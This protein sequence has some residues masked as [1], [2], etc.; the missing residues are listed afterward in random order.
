MNPLIKQAHTSYLG[1]KGAG[2]GLM[3]ADLHVHTNFSPDGLSSPKEIVKAAIEKNIDC[4]CI[5]DHHEIKGAIEAMKF[6]FDKNILIIS[7]IE[8]L[9]TSG[10]VLGINVKKI[11][12][13]GLSVEKTIEEIRKQGGMAVIPHPFD[14]PVVNFRGGEKKLC[15]IDFD[16]IEAFNSSVIFKS[17]NQK[18]FN[19]SQKNNLPITASSDAHRAEFVGRGYIEISRSIL[20][21]KEVLEEIKNKKVKINGKPLNFWEVFKNS[22]KADL[23]DLYNLKFKN[24]IK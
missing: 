5:T 7:G 20:S 24:R 23:K 18:A 13:D 1:T 10:D 12:P 16:A 11:I 8:I 14:W 9:T 21:E 3:K 15:S 17:A 19:F 22:S 6:S 2:V 4:I